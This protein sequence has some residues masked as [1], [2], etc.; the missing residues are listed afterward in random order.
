MSRRAWAA[1]LA[2]ALAL[3]IGIAGIA[4]VVAGIWSVLHGGNAARP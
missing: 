3:Y 1:A 4:C 2:L